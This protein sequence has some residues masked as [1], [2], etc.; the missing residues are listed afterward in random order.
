MKYSD[1]IAWVMAFIVIGWLSWT[2]DNQQ[3]E[4][5]ILNKEKDLLVGNYL[6]HISEYRRPLW[7]NDKDKQEFLDWIRESAIRQVKGANGVQMQASR[8]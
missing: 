4:I 8:R 5:K 3:G 7:V 6:S 1:L 2:A